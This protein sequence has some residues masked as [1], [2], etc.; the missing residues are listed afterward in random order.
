MPA[1]RCCSALTT[2]SHLACVVPKLCAFHARCIV[3]AASQRSEARGCSKVK[4]RPRLH[5]PEVPLV[6]LELD[7]PLVLLELYLQRALR[8]HHSQCTRAEDAL[9]AA[10]HDGLLAVRLVPPQVRRQAA[11]GQPSHRRLQLQHAA[12]V[13][14]ILPLRHQTI[15]H[16][17]PGLSAELAAGARLD[18]HGCRATSRIAPRAPLASPL[19]LRRRVRLDDTHLLTPLFDQHSDTVAP[20][21]GGELAVGHL[22]LRL[23][24]RRDRLDEALRELVPAREH[25]NVIASIADA[26]ARQRPDAPRAP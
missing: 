10:G 18:A 11:A 21:L 8:G 2:S 9:D 25:R 26:S 14:Q 13:A 23:L 5:Q 12:L 22:L 3:E 15:A 1:A 17:K 6:L 16:G 24:A 4:V 7:L 19:L 20:G